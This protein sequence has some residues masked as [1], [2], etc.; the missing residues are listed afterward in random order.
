MTLITSIHVDRDDYQSV[1]SSADKSIFIKELKS[2]REN[3]ELVSPTDMLAALVCYG[4]LTIKIGIRRTGIYHKKKGFF[5]DE[6]NHL[7]VFQGSG[8]ET[9]TALHPDIDEGSAEEFT[10]FRNWG[11]EHLQSWDSHGTPHWEKLT[12]EA[13][14]NSE[15]NTP[16]ISIQD[17]DPEFFDFIEGD[18]WI[19]LE[20][21]R[22]QSKERQQRLAELWDQ[23]F[24]KPAPEGIIL[25][26]HQVEGITAWKQNDFRGILKH[27]TGSGKT[28]TALSCIEEHMQ[29]GLPV[30][31]LVPGRI[32]LDQWIEEIEKFVDG[33]DILPVGAGHREWRRKLGFWLHEKPQV[34][35]KRV[36]VAIIHT[37]RTRQ[38]LDQVGNLDSTLLVVDECHRIGA[39]SF[40]EI[41]EWKPGKVLG[42]SATPERYGDQTG[43]DQIFSICGEVIHEY[44][45]K[46]AIRDG[47]LSKYFYYVERVSLTDDES[48]DYNSM[49]AEIGIWLARVRDSG[50]N[51]NFNS[52]PE[53]VQILI[54]QA[55]NIIKKAE[56]KTGKCAEIVSQNYI[57]DGTQYWLVYCQDSEQLEE[58]RIEL[59]GHRI[60]PVYVY[61]SGAEG[62]TVGDRSFEFKRKETLE[63]WEETGGIMLAIQCLDEG[64]NIECI[65][66][67]IVLASSLN[68][69]Q[70]IQRRGRMLRLSENKTHAKIWDTLVIPNN[71]NAGGRG[72]Y[73]LG[74]L[75]RAW[76][77]AQ[78]ADNAQALRELTNIRHELGLSDW[79]TDDAIEDEDDRNE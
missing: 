47:H 74:E 38:F 49:M 66:H 56:M 13:S 35:L 55:K 57:G 23:H 68:P 27:A 28:I 21:H 17:V 50:G 39:P 45:L 12:E 7:V 72:N 30:I 15:E 76:E 10:T 24:S 52:L 36:V 2:M 65:S 5:R 40:S 51:L 1:I 3:P 69:R 9:R 41:L 42:L 32:L 20:K 34:E 77:F 16:I 58:I 37:A 61:W 75:N 19:D 11:D 22:P 31:V 14:G 8:N 59:E 63:M 4:C 29:Q 46:E 62:A 54:F 67:G 70:F 60:G 53:H 25:R 18:D 64:V 26:P 78:S 48:E 6:C 73:V 44:G 33:P 79:F 71:Q 43:T